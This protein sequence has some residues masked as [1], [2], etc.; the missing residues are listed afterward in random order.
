MNLRQL[1]TLTSILKHGSFAAAG[2]H[3]GLSHAAVSVQM[4]QLETT[5]AAELFDRSSRPVT[6]TADGVRIAQ[7]ADEVLD[8]VENLRLEASGAKTSGAVSIGFIPT[9]VH[10]LLPRVLD[11][12]RKSFPDLQVS[13]KSGLSS[14]LAAA[15]V[16]RELDFAL[17]TT[18]LA[19]IPELDISAIASEPFYV[20]GP[21]GT[22][23]ESDASLLRS[24]P[25][26]A[27]NKR[28]W[29]GQHIAAKLQQRGIHIQA[30]IEIDS[31]EA[32]ENLVADGFGV[33]IVPLRLHAPARSS[34]L[35]QIPFG[36]PV[37]TRQLT[38]IHHL[39]K[40]QSRLDSAIKHIFLELPKP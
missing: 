22:A 8:K 27:F 34:K 2:D 36:N 38:L 9:C 32:I 17:V 40:P 37:D 15:V 12:L 26:I 21:A 3:I 14:E 18:P 16:R 35:V 7:L 19:E 20:I 25:Y 24:L 5:L 33:S 4:N 6:L 39:G 13:V 10:H 23:V 11:A 30:A 31:L 1:R 29:V 28:T